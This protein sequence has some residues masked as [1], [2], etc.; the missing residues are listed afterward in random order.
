LRKLLHD[1]PVNLYINLY[2]DKE[3]IDAFNYLYKLIY[4]LV[5]TP[6]WAFLTYPFVVARQP[7]CF[8]LCAACSRDGKASLY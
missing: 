1:A 8:V 4:N 7:V 3:F 6:Q 2:K 5:V